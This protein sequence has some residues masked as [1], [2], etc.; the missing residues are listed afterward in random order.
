MGTA[1]SF[2]SAVPSD[3]RD[4]LDLNLSEQYSNFMVPTGFSLPWTWYCPGAGPPDSKVIL[5]FNL[6]SVNSEQAL[7]Y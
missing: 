3:F 4:S 1:N 7:F 5:I 6:N 2:E